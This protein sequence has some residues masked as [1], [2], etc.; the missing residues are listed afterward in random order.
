MLLQLNV[1]PYGLGQK[2]NFWIP[3]PPISVLPGRF[4]CCISH[5]KALLKARSVKRAA[6]EKHCW[7][8][9]CEPA[10]LPGQEPS[11]NS[12]LPPQVRP[13]THLAP[14]RWARWSSSLNNCKVGT[15]RSVEEAHCKNLMPAHKAFSKMEGRFR[16]GF[17][18]IMVS[19]VKLDEYKNLILTGSNSFLTLYLH[20][21]H[22][23]NYGLALR[24]CRMACK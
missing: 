3:S 10:W 24:I 2:Q 19:K 20:L 16:K 9:L 1:I 23:N 5:V 18:V 15:P 21:L 7:A 8:V 6:V 12:A 11:P 13:H 17:S 14:G 22:F 4:C